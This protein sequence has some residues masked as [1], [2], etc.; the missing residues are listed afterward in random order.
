ME[1]KQN[2]FRVYNYLI[3]LRENPDE[4]KQVS[5]ALLQYIYEQVLSSLAEQVNGKAE[6]HEKKQTIGKNMMED[7]IIDIIPANK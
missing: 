3:Y 7:N 5:I 4:A 2:N 1:I 6:E